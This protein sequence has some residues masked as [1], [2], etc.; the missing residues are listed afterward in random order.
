MTDTTEPG[1]LETVAATLPHDVAYIV[2]SRTR[3]GNI[4]ELAAVWAATSTGYAALVVAVDDDD[5][6]LE[7][8]LELG[9]VLADYEH[10]REWFRMVVGERL[11]LGGTLNQLAPVFA[12]DRLAV[13]FM[14]DDH[15]PRTDGWDASVAA[16]IAGRRH[17]IAYGDD[18]IQRSALP[19]AVALDSRIVLELGY[20]VP[21]GLVHLYLDN[22]WLELGRRLGT[23]RYL[24]DVVIE[25][26]HPTAGTAPPDELYAEVNHPDQYAADEARFRQYMATELTDAVTLLN[27]RHYHNPD[28]IIDV[29][30]ERPTP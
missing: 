6:F 29:T 5:P 3:P 26:C 14:G 12:V 10:T 8:Y 21:P 15:R 11:R 24:D 7:D 16:A 19:T 30:T 4:A 22:Y 17:V 25:H 23:L 20:M 18:L 27:D 13:G 9:A 1:R 28:A 2:P